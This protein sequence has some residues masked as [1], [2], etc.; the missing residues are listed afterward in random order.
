[1]YGLRVLGGPMVL[2]FDG[3]PV[4]LRP[5]ERVVMLDDRPP[6]GRTTDTAAS[7]VAPEATA[8]DPLQPRVHP[9]P[10]VS[11][12]PVCGALP[13][14]ILLQV[15]AER[16]QFADVVELGTSIFARVL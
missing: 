5:M 12:L 7:A 6:P 3:R 2:E 4:R 11:R 8:H 14:P 13:T 9:P 16:F 10:W 15:V 1:M